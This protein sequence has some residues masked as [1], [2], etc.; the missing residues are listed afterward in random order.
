MKALKILGAVFGLLIVAIAVTLVVGIPG[1]FVTG[2]IEERIE[3]ETGLQLDINGGATIKLWPLTVVTLSDVALYD[4]KD[5]DVPERFRAA[6]IRAELSLRSLLTGHPRVRE[7]NIVRPVV[8][9]PMA[10]ERTRQV[11]TGGRSTASL[12]DVPLSIERVVISDA[13]ILFKD[14]RNRVEQK[15][16]KLNVKA[17]A[18][19]GRKLDVTADARSGDQTFKLDA[20]ATVPGGPVDGLTVPIDFKLDAPGTLPQA[21]SGNGEIK[22]GGNTIAIN[23]LSGTLGAARF[24]GHASVEATT[25]PLVKV[26]LDF[27]QLDLE[28][29]SAV[30]AKSP[31][32]W[33]ETPIKLDGLNY[34][35]A[36]FQISAATLNVGT[37]KLT[38]V[39]VEGT[40]AS[41][42]V[43]MTLSEIGLYDGRAAVGLALDASIPSPIYALR[44]DLRGVRA[45][46]L[47][48]SAAD[49]TWL[50]GKMQAQLDVRTS[51]R[52]Q[53]EMVANLSGTTNVDFQD[54]QIRGINV[55]QMI[56]NL[57]SSTLNGWQENGVQSTDLTE[58]HANF[59][60]EKGSA[61]TTDLRLAGPLV[62]ITGT[63]SA[64]LNTKSLSFRLEPK[65]VMTTQGQGSNVTDPIGL[66]VPV[67]M[68]GTWAAPRIY[69]DMAGILDNPDAAFAKL[70]ELGQGLFGP[71]L[72]G[73]TADGRPSQPG[74]PGP[75]GNQL[76]EGIGALIQGLGG[77][78]QGRPGT[79]AP[80][81]AQPAQPAPAPAPAPQ[82]APFS[83]GQSTQNPPGQNSQSQ[84]TQSQIDTV[85]RQLFGR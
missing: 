45:L 43:R 13:T 71:G 27:K 52:N 48:T 29:P 19:P 58:L 2:A 17:I 66:G 53:R 30:G 31:Q 70:R 82:A 8:S 62:R 24:S 6:D 11:S 33:S 56:R 1:G 36:D 59:R 57:T 69:P 73:G 21:L 41:G 76:I 75:A 35:D 16:E 74:Q 55:A 38:P 64:D 7:I 78:G 81:T 50:D 80:Q 37:L 67:V 42:I 84:N 44:A 46:P 20:K 51:G 83:Q 85:I 63:G 22:L 28:T 12:D 34:V 25:K 15:L 3:K 49:F 61:A 5:K 77:A 18:T 10:R 4:P 54:G 23:N 9:V 47:L 40:L 60:I 26:N 32:G 65:L 39:K 79:A 68:E 72:F 14:P